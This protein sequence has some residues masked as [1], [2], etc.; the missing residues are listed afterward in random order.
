MTMNEKREFG[1]SEYPTVWELLAGA[2]IIWGGMAL[3]WVAM[4]AFG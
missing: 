2:V 1:M 3:F 4:V